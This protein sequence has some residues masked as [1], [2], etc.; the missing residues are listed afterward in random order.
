M[1]NLD[2]FNINIE[3]INCISLEEQVKIYQKIYNHE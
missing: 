3:K 1:N 2:K